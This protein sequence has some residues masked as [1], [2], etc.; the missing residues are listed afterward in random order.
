MA[1]PGDNSLLR[2][3]EAKAKSHNEAAERAK[4]EYVAALNDANNSMKLKEVL[5]QDYMLRAELVAK[6]ASETTQLAS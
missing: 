6:S 3:L 4:A 1:L 2:D 5:K